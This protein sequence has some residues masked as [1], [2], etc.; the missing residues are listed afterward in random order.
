MR[1][2]HS[3]VFICN[4][5][6]AGLLGSGRS[7]WPQPPD[8]PAVLEASR[9]H[10]VTAPLAWCLRGDPRVP[11]DVAARLRTALAANAA[12]NALIL[13]ELERILTALGACGLE[14]LLLKGAAH[15]VN[16]LYPAPSVRFLTDIDLLLPLDRLDAGAAALQRI[17]FAPP[18]RRAFVEIDYQHLPRMTHPPSGIGVELHRSVFAPD[19]AV[20]PLAAFWHTAR[21]VP[22]RGA[23]V[24]VPG[25]TAAVAHNIAHAQIAHDLR[26]EGHAELRQLLDLALLCRREG[27]AI[28]W[29]AIAEGFSHAGFER[30]LRDNLAVAQAL[31]GETVPLP[32]PAADGTA[33]ARL[34]LNTERPRQRRLARLARVASRYVERLRRR[35]ALVLN[36]LA[37]GLWPARLRLLAAALRP[38]W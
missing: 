24:R 36:V 19:H 4:A 27:P 7:A 5:L 1:R 20:L 15:L 38:R 22:F 23:T 33:V 25:A 3:F 11:G 30:A 10:G 17:G 35:P 16:G 31:F 21:A 12:R 9:H 32:D 29:P 6:R 13:R 37:P 28:D 18:P 14:P 34:R 2:W 26:R 8:W